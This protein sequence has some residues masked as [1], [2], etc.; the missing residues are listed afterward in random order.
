VYISKEFGKCHPMNLVALSRTVTVATCKDEEGDNCYILCSNPK[1]GDVF[2]FE[3]NG[4]WPYDSNPEP[5]RYGR[6]RDEVY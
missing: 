2:E 6:E 1:V 3:K 4:F 5:N